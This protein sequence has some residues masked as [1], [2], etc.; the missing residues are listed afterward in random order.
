MGTFGSGALTGIEQ[1]NTPD[2]S[3]EANSSIREVQP[4]AGTPP[5]LT[6]KNESSVAVRSCATSRTAKAIEPLRDAVR[7]PTPEC[8]TW[9]FAVLCLAQK[10]S[11][12]NCVRFAFLRGICFANGAVRQLNLFPFEKPNRPADHPNGTTFIISFCSNRCPGRT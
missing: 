10:K 1:T 5:S 2:K 3:I 11:K 6:P 8:R 12:R 9:A 4:R 7:P